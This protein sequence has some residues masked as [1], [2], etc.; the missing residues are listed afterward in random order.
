MGSLLPGG[1]PEVMER[2]RALA[3]AARKMLCDALEVAEP[4]PAKFIGSLAVIPLPKASKEQLPR[5][6]F[7]ES[8]LQDAL[9]IKHKIE[10]PII[11]WPAPPTRWLRISAQLYNSLPDYERLAVALKKE[12]RAALK[13][14][15]APSSSDFVISRKK[16]SS[17]C[18]IVTFRRQ[19]NQTR[20][21]E[22]FM[23]RP[24][25]FF[26]VESSAANDGQVVVQS[27]AGFGNLWKYQN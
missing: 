14:A 7:N 2:N 1:W 23:N 16:C 13:R 21:N 19:R 18:N 22:V 17:C 8:P 3:L 26:E 5:L 15:L 12:L 9:R 11:S 24:G 10:V 25:H 27:S 20:L 6:P 4:C